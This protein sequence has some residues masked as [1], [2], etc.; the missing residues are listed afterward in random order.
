MCTSRKE[1]RVASRVFVAVLLIQLAAFV[2]LCS[3]QDLPQMGPRSA[4]EGL[5]ENKEYA[6][7]VLVPQ[8][9]SG[10]RAVAPAPSHGFVL[11]LCKNVSN[12]TLAVDGSYN[13]TEAS[14]L[15]EIARASVAGLGRAS[16]QFVEVPVQHGGLAGLRYTAAYFSRK[17]GSM[18]RQTGWVALQ[19][20][21]GGLSIIYSIIL[22]TPVE[23]HNDYTNIFDSV[24]GTFLT[25]PLG[26]GL[27]VR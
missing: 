18:R 11:E 6:Y 8:G 4:V 24:L 10:L 16:S 26:G 9:Y 7:S 19:H 23:Q 17:N 27:E 3:A 5:Y 2:S 20:R 14:S 21:V 22:D 25:M 15:D 1:M 12:C 13:T